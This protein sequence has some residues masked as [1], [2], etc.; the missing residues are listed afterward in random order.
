M[1]QICQNKKENN[2]H[3]I[4][5]LSKCVHVP[6]LSVNDKGTVVFRGLCEYLLQHLEH[7]QHRFWS[8]PENSQLMSG[9]YVLYVFNVT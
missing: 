9:L 8:I 5:I 2:L 4:V 6:L 1:L 3:I 7:S